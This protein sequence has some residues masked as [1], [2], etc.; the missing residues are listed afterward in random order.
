VAIGVVHI[1]VAE[2]CSELFEVIESCIDFL[3]SLT[4]LQKFVHK[5]IQTFLEL[6]R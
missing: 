3:K 1:G 4:K 5:A 6:L 2:I